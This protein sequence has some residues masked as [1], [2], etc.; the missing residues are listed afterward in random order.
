MTTLSKEIIIPKDM[1]LFKA[2]AKIY[3]AEQFY[4]GTLELNDEITIT[5]LLSKKD[6]EKLKQNG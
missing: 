5:I 4:T 3:L 2:P 6:Y 1:V